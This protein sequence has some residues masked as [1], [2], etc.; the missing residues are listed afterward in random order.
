MRMATLKKLLAALHMPI[1]NQLRLI[2]TFRS[3]AHAA[4]WGRSPPFIKDHLEKTTSLSVDITMPFLDSASVA[5]LFSLFPNVRDLELQERI[6]TVLDDD[7]SLKLDH[8]H[9][10]TSIALVLIS[11]YRMITVNFLSLQS[12]LTREYRTCKIIVS[13]REYD[14]YC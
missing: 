11:T 7:T 12:F 13:N 1:V 6:I 3:W 8:L 5:G 4:S 2:I 14:I 10:V 9:S